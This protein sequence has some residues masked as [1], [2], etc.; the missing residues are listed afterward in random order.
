[1]VA[2]QRARLRA[3]TA[4]W[5]HPLL[6]L[7]LPDWTCFHPGSTRR[8][9]STAPSGP[10]HVN[11]TPG[12]GTTRAPGIWVLP[13]D[14]CARVYVARACRIGRTALGA[15]S[16]RERVPPDRGCDAS[17]LAEE[18]RRLLARQPARWDSCHVPSTMSVSP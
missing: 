1:M 15:W 16:G 10:R 5:S 4:H 3:S 17:D 2:I 12:I 7:N 8:W 11:Q 9:V 14:V 6:A 13:T 18:A